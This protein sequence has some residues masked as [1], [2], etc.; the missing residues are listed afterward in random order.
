MSIFPEWIGPVGTGPGG[1]TLLVV[2]GQ[3]NADFTD[4]GI[5]GQLYNDEITADIEDNEIIGIVT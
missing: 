5:Q 1:I 2:A 4:E 3:L